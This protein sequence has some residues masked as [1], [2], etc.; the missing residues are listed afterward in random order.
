MKTKQ[1]ES[2]AQKLVEK[3]KA[4]DN[5]KYYCKV[6][7]SLPEAVIWNNLESATRQGVKMPARYFTTLCNKAIKEK[8]AR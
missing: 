4:P 6:A 1:V 5:Y 3:L 8:V 2:T 7:Y